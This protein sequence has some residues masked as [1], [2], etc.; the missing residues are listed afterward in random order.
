MTYPAQPGAGPALPQVNDPAAIGGT[1]TRI[2]DLRNRC[3]IVQPIAI[4]RSVPG[5]KAGDVQDRITA[6]IFVLDGGPL[7]FGGKPEK[8]V[9]HTLV[10]ATP[11]VAEGIYISQVNLVAALLPSLPSPQSPQGGLVIGVIEQGITNTPG[12]NPPWNLTLLDPADPR[13]GLAAQILQR[14]FTGQFVN[15]EPQQTGAP[16]PPGG[17]LA[18]THA[19]TMPHDPATGQPIPNPAEIQQ[20]PYTQAA[21]VAPASTPAAPAQDPQYLEWLASRGAAQAA[22]VSAAPAAAQNA[23]VPPGPMPGGFYGI[24]NTQ[25]AAPADVPPA[26]WAPETWGTFTPEQKAA[27]RASLQ[28]TAASAHSSAMPPF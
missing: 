18:Y 15:P 3:V 8:Y 25:P 13:R 11:Y 10:V 27:I 21:Y 22:P 19:T 16:M 7:Q 24:G 6:N 17:P 14:F 28:P 20:H 2:A 12:N 5:V 9:P 1:R 4:A 26:G 23:T